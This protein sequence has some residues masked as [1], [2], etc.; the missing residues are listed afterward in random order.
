MS[1]W[2]APLAPAAAAME[3]P[4]PPLS[5]ACR[6][7]RTEWARSCLDRGDD[8]EEETDP[9]G[10][11]P[12][13]YA[14]AVGQVDLVLLLLDHGA[15]VDR[16][17]RDG[18][19]P[20]FRA[21]SA[22]H[23]AAATLLADRGADVERA[24]PP[25]G[26]S[27]LCAACLGGHTDAARLC[28]DRGADVNRRDQNGW[29]PLIA[30]SRQGSIDVARLCLERGAATEDPEPALPALAAYNYAHGMGH[31]AMAAWLARIRRVGWKIHLSEP[32]YQLVV[33][34]GLLARRRA[35]REHAFHGKELA[36][37]FLFP[38]PSDQPPPQATSSKQAKP[39]PPH[40]PNSLFPLVAR[41][42]WGGGMSAE[43]EAA[44]ATERCR[45][46]RG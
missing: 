41:Y 5:L 8:I 42:Y 37:D 30:A 9:S 33:L 26:R 1:F 35:R 29:S 15:V 36:L 2:S 28:L 43:E 16:A 44:A 46:S 13:M 24:G 10:W 34:R 27:P 45:R 21:C 19:T 18:A 31:R 20:F 22:G 39:G 14:C 3:S 6:V 11:S 4:M 12:L 38:S 17:D 32:R 25:W 7:G 40:L 23:A